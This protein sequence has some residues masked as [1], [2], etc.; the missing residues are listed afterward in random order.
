MKPT[1]VLIFACLVTA[2]VCYHGCGKA[3]GNGS[4]TAE[5]IAPPPGEP[6]VE[7]F[8][9]RNDSGEVVGGNCTR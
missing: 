6:R 1:E 7:C 3:K 2:L 8:A 5:L 4:A 9:V